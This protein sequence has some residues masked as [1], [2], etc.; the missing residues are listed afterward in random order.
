MKNINIS[1]LIWV[2]SIFVFLYYLSSR[3]LIADVYKYAWVST[4]VELLSIPMLGL[5][6]SIPIISLLQLIK[7]KGME[8]GYVI[9]SLILI[10][11]SIAILIQGT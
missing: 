2:L 11:A 4:I 9:G 3:I 8:R 1:K 7:P 10:G 6:V 5:L